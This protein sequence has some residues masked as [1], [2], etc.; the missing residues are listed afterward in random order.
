MPIINVSDSDPGL[1]TRTAAT[2]INL[3]QQPNRAARIKLGTGSVMVVG[4]VVNDRGQVAEPAILENS[5]D[6][7]NLYGGFAPWMGDAIPAGLDVDDSNDF[8]DR[9]A[10]SGYLGNLHARLLDLDA[11]KVVILIPDLALKDDSIG[12]ATPGA[13]VL[14]KVTRGGTPTGAYTLPAGTRI[15]DAHATLDD[16]VV[17]TLEPVVWGLGVADEQS[18]RVRKVSPIST[19]NVAIDTVDTFID[20]PPTAETI[21]ITTTAVTVADAFTAAELVLRYIDA[22]D[23]GVDNAAGRIANFV[24]SDRDEALVEDEV[25][26]HCEEATAQGYFRQAFVGPPKGTSAADARGTTGEGIGRAALKREFCAYCHPGVQREFLTDADNLSA[27]NN[28]STVMSSKFAACFLAAQFRPE[29]NPAQPHSILTTYKM[30]GVEPIAGGQPDRA[31]HEQAGIW[32][33]VLEHGYPIGGLLPTFHASPNADATQ[34]FDRKRMGFFIDQNII[35]LAINFH[36]SLASETNQLDFIDIVD[37]FLE[38]LVTDERIN[39]YNPTQG[40]WDGTNREF[41]IDVEAFEVG[42]MDVI[43]IRR[44]FGA[45]PGLR[46]TQ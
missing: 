30:V 20:T 3:I 22:L 40:T 42:S 8:D 44:S 43:T 31:T 34:P 33:P 5:K 11:Q 36:K 29:E 45:A 17:A 37:G 6:V 46:A 32:Q 9:G 25:S 1:E 26:V 21:T 28:Y 4:A 39:S 7:N 35:A 15:T 16:F 41:T 19:P 18:V 38:R 24:I 13:D 23:H 10:S 27:E 2:Q 12:A 14:V